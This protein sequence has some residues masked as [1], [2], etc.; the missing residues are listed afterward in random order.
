MRSNPK[1]MEVLYLTKLVSNKN[2][3]LKKNMPTLIILIISGAFIYALPYFRN[4]Y[5]DTFVEIFRI[6]NTQMGALGSVYGITSMISFCFGGFCADRWPTK[7]LLPISLISTGVLGLTLLTYPPYPIVFLVHALWGV[8]C[9]LTF[10]NALII[11]IRALASSDEQGKVFGFF[12]GGRG[13]VNIVQSAFVLGLFSYLC[14]VSTEQKALSA[15]IMT[16]SVICILLGF[17]VFFA[18]E[19][20]VTVK[21]TGDKKILETA[22]LRKILKMPTTWLCSVIIFTS[23]AV[24]ISYF[25]ITP[26]TTSVFGV[27]PVI[28]AALGYFSQYCRPLGCF[29]TGITADKIGSSKMMAIAYLI[30]IVGLLGVI[31]VPGQPSMIGLLLLSIAAIYVSMYGIQSLHYAILEEGEY[32]LEITGT[33]TAIIM[34]IGYSSEF[35]VPITAGF[36][37][38]TYPGL[39]G[40]KIFFGILTAMCVIGLLTVMVWMHVTKEKRI[41]MQSRRF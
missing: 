22:V 20:K 33:A 5:Y 4:Y 41:Q 26:Y 3:Q 34:P 13:I 10:W 39:Q 29:F 11:A 30:L 12:E 1:Q 9:V 17:L 25:Y 19:K 16:Y 32:P 6:T 2:S 24:I 28:A 38:D 31:A 18:L 40:Y 23:Y 15:V 7:Y 21:G 27:S 37:L 14:K 36:C 35:I 8:T